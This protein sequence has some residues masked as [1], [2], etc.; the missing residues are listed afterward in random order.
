[1]QKFWKKKRE[2]KKKEK[3]EKV[4]VWS[5]KE[6][7]EDV[8]RDDGYECDCSNVSCQGHIFIVSWW[9]KSKLV[10]LGSSFKTSHF[11]KIVTLLKT[12]HFKSCDS[13]EKLF[14]SKSL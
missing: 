12:S 8:E 3:K 7:K 14:R 9:L 11:L 13:F 10:T 6:M 4:G 5:L 1:M 2:E